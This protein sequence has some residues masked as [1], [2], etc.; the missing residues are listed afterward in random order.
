M[1]NM[2]M[3]FVNFRLSGPATGNGARNWWSGM[4]E[5]KAYVSRKVPEKIAPR[6]YDVSVRLDMQIHDMSAMRTATGRV[7]RPKPI[8]QTVSAQVRV[9]GQGQGSVQRVETKPGEFAEIREALSVTGVQVL[10][11]DQYSM[12]GKVEPKFANI[13]MML[14]GPSFDEGGMIMADPIKDLQCAYEVSV[15]IDGKAHRLLSFISG[16]RGVMSPPDASTPWATWNRWSMTSRAD[17]LLKVPE[18]KK[19]KVTFKPR[20]EFAQQ[21]IDQRGYR[22]DEVVFE[23]VPVVVSDTRSVKTVPLAKVTQQSTTSFAA[24]GIMQMIGDGL[25]V[26]PGSDDEPEEDEKGKTKP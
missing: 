10:V 13:S 23:D 17:S 21:S 1:Q 12:R 19:A 8:E 26:K 15:E 4:N 2:A 11:S 9:L 5:R 20:P 24:R 25:G 22:A 14:S 6:D 18:A 3:N 7:T 16:K